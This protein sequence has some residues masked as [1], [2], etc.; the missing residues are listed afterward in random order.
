MIIPVIHLMRSPP[1]GA[2]SS[3]TIGFIRNTLVIYYSR[4]S[5][6]NYYFTFYFLVVVSNHNQQLRIAMRNFR[7][8]I[9]MSDLRLQRKRNKFQGF[10]FSVLITIK[11]KPPSFDPNQKLKWRRASVMSIF[12]GLVIIPSCRA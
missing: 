10:L 8:L 9:R 7:L 11:A 1:Q 12:L 4:E 5:P 2:H 3:S 6:K